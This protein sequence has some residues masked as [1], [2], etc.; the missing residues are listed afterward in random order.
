M[1]L[2]E[3]DCNSL[4][5]CSGEIRIWEVREGRFDLLTSAQLTP[6]VGSI[7]SLHLLPNRIDVLYA[8]TGFDQ[9][10][11][12]ILGKETTFE[13]VLQGNPLGIL[14]LTVHPKEESFFTSSGDNRLQKWDPRHGVE[15][16]T[17]L[18]VIA[19]CH[20]YFMLTQTDSLFSPPSAVS[21]KDH[22]SA[23]IHPEKC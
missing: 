16:E 13:L 19:F 4:P 21:R 7:I 15:W 8:T 5:C 14:C 20:S 2:K 1:F 23:F 17:T 12:V 6:D 3:S 18:P 10:F 22:Q 11:K 9:V